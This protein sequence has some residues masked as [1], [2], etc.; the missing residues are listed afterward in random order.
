[1]KVR[2]CA[3]VRDFRRRSGGRARPGRA[4]LRGLTKRTNTDFRCYRQNN[5]GIDTNRSRKRCEEGMKSCPILGGVGWP[6]GCCWVLTGYTYKKKGDLKYGASK[7]RLVTLAPPMSSNKQHVR[8]VQGCGASP[9]CSRNCSRLC[10]HAAHPATAAACGRQA[11]R[12]KS[13]PERSHESPN[14]DPCDRP[15]GWFA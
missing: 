2:S 6:L 4:A 12:Q 5:T 13:P 15:G 3:A 9:A 14:G 7:G 8:G 1:M 10:T 11:T